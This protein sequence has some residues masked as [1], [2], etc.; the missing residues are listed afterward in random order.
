MVY[1]HHSKR[2]LTLLSRHVCDDT[3]VQYISKDDVVSMT[4]S[5]ERRTTGSVFF[6]EVTIA[7]S[8]YLTRHVAGG[9]PQIKT[10]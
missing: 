4:M 1:L 9:G 2:F 7:I 8:H 6:L 5:G 3:R 10:L